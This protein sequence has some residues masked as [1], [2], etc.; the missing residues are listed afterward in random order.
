MARTL[1]ESLSEQVQFMR[2]KMEEIMASQTEQGNDFGDF[3]QP[4]VQTESEVLD[5]QPVSIVQRPP[6]VQVVFDIHEAPKIRADENSVVV[7]QEHAETQ[8]VGEDGHGVEEG[9][10]AD[11]EPPAVVPEPSHPDTRVKQ[12][13]VTEMP[14]EEKNYGRFSCQA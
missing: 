6:D 12:V 8:V 11:I 1:E 13:L 14:P 4:S 7:V 10:V 2:S 3:M 9:S 5:R